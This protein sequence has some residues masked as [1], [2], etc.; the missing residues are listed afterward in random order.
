M[1]ILESHPNYGF[2]ENGEVFNL[3]FERQ[4]KPYVSATTGYLYITLRHKDGRYRP[5]SL[6]R[7]VAKLYIDNP[8]NL[9]F[10]NH[11][12]GNKL[13]PNKNNLEWTDNSRNIQHAYDIGL[14]PKGEDRYNNVNPVEKIHHVCQLLQE[15]IFSNKEIEEITG[16][17]YKTIGQIKYGKQWKDISSIYKW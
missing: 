6:H 8:N 13:N 11:I 14:I 7:C 3:K 4:L 1:K 16:V 2:T 15:G 5:T 17:N 9:P 12:D 10:V